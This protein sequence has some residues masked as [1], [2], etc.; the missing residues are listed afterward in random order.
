MVAIT[1]S[2]GAANDDLLKAAVIPVGSPDHAA[3]T[4]E[5]NNPVC[6][7]VALNAADPPAGIDTPEDAAVSVKLD[8]VTVTVT[9][10]LALKLPLV[11]FNESANGPAAMLTGVVN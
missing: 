4:A 9:G 6:V 1:P 3:L 5:L 10:T 2:P 8:A 7:A 11:A